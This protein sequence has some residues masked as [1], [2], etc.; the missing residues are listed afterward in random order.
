MK[1]PSSD[2]IKFLWLFLGLVLLNIASFYFYQRFDL[3]D[4]NRY[5]LSPEA[6]EIIDDLEAPIV[7]DVFLKGDF[8][9]QFRKL[10]LE[11][12]QLLEEFAAFNPN[13]KFNFINPLEGG[14]DA[15]AIATE[16]YNM[17]MT[18]AR[19][20]V[21]ENGRSSETIIFPWAM[22]NYGE[23]T[24]KI[25]LLKNVLG[26]TTEERVTAS[27]EQL[28][29]AFADAFSKLVNPKRRKI[30]VMRGNGELP[31]RYIADFVRSLQDYYFTA[32]FTLDSVAVNPQETL[33]N[34]KEYDLVIEA[35]PTE[36]YTEQEKF[37]LD[38]YL[39]SGGKML[40]MVDRV[41][42]ETDS[43]FSA[44]QSALAYSQELNLGD[45]FFK[46]GVRINPLLVKDLY[47]AP[48][49][50]ASG[51]GSN[52]VFTPYP[53]PFYPLASTPNNHP[54]NIDI[55]PVKFEYASPIDT[56]E[57]GIAK[58]VL[59]SSSP[60]TKLQGIPEVISLDLIAKKPD[61]STYNNG[62]QPLAVLLEGEFTS[63]YKNRIKPFELENP[64]DQSSA[65][66]MIVIS[67]GNVV[68]NQLQRGEVL[69]LGFDRYTG[70]TYGN[71]EFLINSVNYLLNDTGLLELRSKK[72]SI[73]FLD[74]MEVEEKRTYWQLINIL[75]PLGILLL[76]AGLFFLYR[77]MKYIRR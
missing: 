69:E 53:W 1:K 59:L 18:P 71:K 77:K 62:P 44:D 75:A 10:Q 72:I 60:A 41:A 24:V 51:S 33:E 34:L 35:R 70:N 57:N 21:V 29:Y 68:K 55:G 58:T 73:A 36:P 20:N 37:V 67:D 15:A 28:Q 5:T 63:V 54:V 42:M 12:R 48:I 19:I 43:L 2:I 56:L 49:V 16:F 45:Y 13:I 31:D 76:F 26:A 32:A 22:A 61:F 50:L 6:K 74:L 52:T 17:G 3:T 14:G 65:T 25:P 4:D 9:A 39:M 23:E 8:P 40:W 64:L 66:A 27:I 46:Y 30:A 7:V 11:T 38:Q 47:S